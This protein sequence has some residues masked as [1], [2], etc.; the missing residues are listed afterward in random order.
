MKRA[1]LIAS[2]VAA[3]VLVAGCGSSDD[4]TVTETSIVAAST[5]TSETSST[6]TSPSTTD[7]GAPPAADIQATGLTGFTS[8]S[9]NI[10]CY[11]DKRSVRCDISKRDWDPPARPASCN[12]NVDYG[13][14]IQMS[15]GGA[16]KFVCAGDTALGGGDPL[17][18]GQSI[19]AGLLRCDS[20]ESG[21]TC[22]D[23]E[24]GR[25]FT[26]STQRYK[27]F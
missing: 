25:G 13:Q 6:A 10:G 16:P 3:A 15:A 27:T 8:P 4:S 11:I 21:M 9:G 23:T 14:G 17:P 26:L 18:Y 1:I 12:E 22:T 7:D 24:T 19:A 5:S 2:A 20:A